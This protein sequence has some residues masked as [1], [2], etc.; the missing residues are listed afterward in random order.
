MIIQLETQK[1]LFNDLVNNFEV[2][3]DNV[4]QNDQ[5]YYKTNHDWGDD[6]ETQWGS[7]QHI[8]DF[9]EKDL[10]EEDA[11]LNARLARILTVDDYDFT[12]NKPI[13]LTPRADYKVDSGA[14][15]K[16]KAAV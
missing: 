6:S 16:V 13:P 9:L 15:S 1:S 11:L 7:Y 4:V 5:N 2:Y 10:T 8:D 3:H 12:N 14:G